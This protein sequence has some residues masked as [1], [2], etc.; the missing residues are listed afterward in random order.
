MANHTPAPWK[1]AG[2]SIISDDFCI[3]VIEDDGGYEAPSKDRRANAIL[4]ATSP[5]L[6]WACRQV[7]DRLKWYAQGRGT[8]YPGIRDDIKLLKTAIAKAEGSNDE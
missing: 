3:A 5:E 1:V 2:T 4:M 6:L 8:R 7:L